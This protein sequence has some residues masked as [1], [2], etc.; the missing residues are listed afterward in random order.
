MPDLSRP[1]RTTEPNRPAPKI[2]LAEDSPTQAIRTRLILEKAGFEV[3]VA[4]D[5][6]KA[7]DRARADRPDAILAD[8]LMPVMDGFQ[9]CMEARLDP[10]LRDVPV[11]LYSA[12]FRASED[13]SFA[14]KLGAVAYIDKDSSPEALCSILKECI[15]RRAPETG[16]MTKEPPLDERRFR[17]LYGERLVSRLVQE[18]AALERAN[19]SLAA[20][21]DATLRALVEALDLRDTETQL[22][23]ARVTQYALTLAA[24]FDL[25]SRFL[26]H[27]QRGS[28][29]HDI[30]KIGVPD[31]ILKKPGPLD[32]SE[33]DA[34][35][36]HSEA[37]YNMVAKIDFL[38]DAADLILAHHERWDGGGYPYGLT[39]EDIPLSARIFAIAD[40][41][42][43]ITSDRP[44]RAARGFEVALDEVSNG[45]AT[46]FDPTLVDLALDIAPAE[47]RRLKEQAESWARAGAS[48][49]T[50]ATSGAA[51]LRVSA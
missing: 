48:G 26:I 32:R 18:A 47:W 6:S 51:G 10:S 9:L 44:Y 12:S 14:L 15:A 16:A 20:A 33:W 2:L 5:G 39:R 13:R 50:T 43:A 29:L 41:V 21:Y 27:L 42:D 40:T 19:E 23:S 25:D 7:L 45:R 1:D 38:H 28:L 49:T 37:G 11:V 17:G 3:A 34:M 46:Q 24:R 31:S 4:E 36:K 35:R 8:V 30:G 22:H